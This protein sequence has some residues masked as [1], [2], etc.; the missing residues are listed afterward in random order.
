MLTN[1]T[2]ETGND[3][4]VKW[5]LVVVALM[6]ADLFISLCVFRAFSYSFFIVYLT[7]RW[8]CCRFTCSHNKLSGVY[9]FT[10]I[11]PYALMPKLYNFNES[12]LKAIEDSY[13]KV[14]LACSTIHKYSVFQKLIKCMNIDHFAN[15]QKLLT[16]CMLLVSF[17]C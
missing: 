10:S 7:R 4:L 1:D 2:K 8:V 6:N 5:I 15:L 17:P 12:K 14:S 11:A 13:S 9:I 16:I 3:S